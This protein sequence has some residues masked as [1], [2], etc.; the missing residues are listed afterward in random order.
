MV[1]SYL[2]IGSNLGN[3]RKNITAALRKIN[4]LQDTKLIKVSPA[5]ETKPVGAP[6]GSGDFLNAA[7][8]IKTNLSAFSL[9]HK[10]K[11]I[12]KDIGRKNSRRNAPRVID[13]DILFYGNMIINSKAL[14][15]PHPRMFE[16]EFVRR[17]LLKLI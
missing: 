1:I 17:A 8:K 2:G 6:A 4:N 5:I 7:A 16:R 13:L 14:V 15:V 10:L 3:R 12:E 11:K 9:L